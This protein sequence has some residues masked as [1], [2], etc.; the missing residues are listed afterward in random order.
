MFPINKY[1]FYSTPDGKTIAV[2][3]YAGRAVRGISRCDDRDTFNE[4]SGRQLAAARCNEK[5]AKKRRMRAASKLQEA[6]DQLEAAQRYYNKMR[7]YYDDSTDEL[8][9]ARHKVKELLLDL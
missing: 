5:I 1:K 3:S 2:S 9:E 4:E 6:S 7:D 8:M